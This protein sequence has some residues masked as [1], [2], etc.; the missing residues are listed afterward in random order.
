M[1]INDDEKGWS[2]EALIIVSKALTQHG[3]NLN[4]LRY[5][6]GAI[7]PYSRPRSW[8]R[9]PLKRITSAPLPGTPSY[10]FPLTPASLQTH[11][12]VLSNWN[13]IKDALPTIP[14]SSDDNDDLLQGL[15]NEKKT[16][17]SPYQLAD[18]DEIDLQLCRQPFAHCKTVSYFEPGNAFL[19]DPK[20]TDHK[21][22]FALLL[23]SLSTIGQNP[24]AINKVTRHLQQPLTTT[25]TRALPSLEIKQCENSTLI[26]GL[27]LSDSFD[28]L[29]RPPSAYPFRLK[30]HRHKR[31]HTQFIL[32]F[33]RIAWR[34][35]PQHCGAG[36]AESV[37]QNE[38]ARLAL[39]RCLRSCSI[40]ALRFKK[41]F[42]HL[43][44]E[45]NLLVKQNHY[46]YFSQY[47]QQQQQHS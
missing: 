19:I 42:A 7:S 2:S 9:I 13:M 29:Q 8:S 3:H 23:N 25:T 27:W 33:Q 12:N 1:Q 22:V 26:S 18:D 16:R 38:K 41:G 34:A 39:S 45:R 17:S 40:T 47:N 35:I 46:R 44:M 37:Q 5:R 36:I 10:R 32:E 20:F 6:R 4:R 31:Q 43:A 11:D 28:S 15:Q 30:L 24:L 21:E 14:E